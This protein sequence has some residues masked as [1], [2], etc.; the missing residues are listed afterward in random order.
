M[1]E[2]V[3][4]VPVG[5]DEVGVISVFMTKFGCNLDIHSRL[6]KKSFPLNVNDRLVFRLKEIDYHNKKIIIAINIQ[7]VRDETYIQP[8][9]VPGFEFYVNERKVAIQFLDLISLG[10]T[11]TINKGTPTIDLSTLDGRDMSSLYYDNPSW[12]KDTE[13][14][15]TVKNTLTSAEPIEPP[16]KLWWKQ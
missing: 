5:F 3:I 4:D 14:V 8:S 9:A 10:L 6:L 15:L 2:L 1:D 7:S 11:F 12:Q 13:V 16:H